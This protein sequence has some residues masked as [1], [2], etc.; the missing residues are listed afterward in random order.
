MAVGMTDS[1]IHIFTTDETL[2]ASPAAEN[3]STSFARP[4]NPSSS[5]SVSKPWLASTQLLGHTD[6]IRAL[7][8]S[9]GMHLT[10]EERS[11]YGYRSRDILL[12]SGSQDN[13]TR[14]WRISQSEGH[15]MH[16]QGD[17]LD[18]LDSLPE[19]EIEAKTYAYTHE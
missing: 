8:F 17:L 2:L 7:S 1:R 5:W 3:P 10:P 19:G 9:D 12:A 11:R 16:I 4:L 14:L 18:D 6:W 15:G 13:Y